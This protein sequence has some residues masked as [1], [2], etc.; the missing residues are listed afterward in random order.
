MKLAFL[1]PLPPSRSGVAHYASML[2][3]E[4]RRHADVTAFGSTDGYVADDFD[5]AI[6]Q[7]GNN[8]HHEFVYA[9]AMRN[10]GVAVLHDVVLHHL[11][12][13]MTLAH[14]DAEGYVAALQASHGQAGAAWARGRAA[15][16]HSEMGNFLLPA[17]VDLARKS[18]AVIV[19]NRWAA[20]RLA[21]FGIETPIHVVPHPYEEEREHHERDAVRAFLGVRPEERVIGLFGFLTSAKRG[22]I[23]VKAFQA[24][25]AR[26]PRIRLLVVGEPAPDID[27]RSIAGEGVTITGYVADDDFGRY[28]AAADRLVNLRYPSAGETSGTLIRAFAAGKPVAVSDY[29]QFAEFPDACVVKIPFGDREV[30]AL[31]DFFVRDLDERGIAAAQHAWLQENARIEM[32]VK[33][34]L[35]AVR[36]SSGAERHLLP[37]GG[38]K[39]MALF[40]GL[41][42]AGIVFEE[43]FAV[44]TLRNDGAFTLPARVYGE[45][46]YRLLAKLFDG[47]REVADH[48]LQ[49]AGDLRP[50]RSAD[51]RIPLANDALTLRIYHALEGIPI[52]DAT[53]A[54]EVE[55]ARV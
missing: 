26:D 18:R 3:P 38:E 53:P 25:R 45:P 40:P 49:L 32:T 27:V 20:D 30:D 51:F 50:G 42:L 46:S 48:W 16:L 47:P 6:Y 37:A 12:V 31:A 17:S 11:V 1:S 55:I 14:G 24:A 4:L 52:V 23:V 8:P 35:E 41:A 9:E 22:E 33:G 39:G 2:L 43:S 28:Y 36:P 34:Y 13:E 10:P 5:V 21:S 19:H 7:L 44:L 15:G 29:A 54:A